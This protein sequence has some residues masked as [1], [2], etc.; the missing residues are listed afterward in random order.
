MSLNISTLET[1]LYERFI[2]EIVNGHI[3]GVDNEGVYNENGL[4]EGG[5]DPDYNS[6]K[7]AQIRDVVEPIFEKIAKIVAEEVINHIKD[8]ATINFSTILGG[9]IETV[10]GTT[11]VFP[12]IPTAGGKYAHVSVGPGTGMMANSLSMLQFTQTSSAAKKVI[13]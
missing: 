4:F 2:T 7:E 6:E 12:G 3:I 5:S 8:N 10:L 13:E 9:T 11:N 1:D